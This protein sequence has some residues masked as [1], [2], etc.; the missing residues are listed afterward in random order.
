MADIIACDGL[1]GLPS[2][3]IENTK[4]RNACCRLNNQNSTACRTLFAPRTGLLDTTCFFF[5]N[6]NECAL[7]ARCRSPEDLYV[8]AEQTNEQGDGSLLL[9]RYR[10]CAHLP[11]MA[12]F[13][14]QGLL[15]PYIHDAVQKQFPIKA[16]DLDSSNGLQQITAS[17]TDCLSATCRSARGSDLCYNKFCSPVRLITNSTFPNLEG[18]NDCLFSMC[19]AGTRALPWVDPDVVGVG[20]SG[21]KPML[22]SV[23]T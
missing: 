22:L 20:V 3:R 5:P 8:S 12:S 11:A 9:A 1:G 13:T 16:T 6:P 21:L 14:A 19:N 10:A 23:I 7:F 17:V 15:V 18:I 4:A 2:L